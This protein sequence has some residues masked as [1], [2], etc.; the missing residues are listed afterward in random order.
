[1]SASGR[2]RR[3][4]HLKL[5]ARS[6]LF[7]ERWYLARYPDVGSQ[8]LDAAVH[9]L[10]HGGLEGRSPSPEFN[11]EW[12][13]ERNADVRQAGLNPLIHFLENGKAEGRRIRPVGEDSKQRAIPRE[14]K[15][16]SSIVGQYSAETVVNSPVGNWRAGRRSFA[17]LELKRESLFST[18]GRG[19]HLASDEIVIDGLAFSVTPS[20]NQKLRLCLEWMESPTSRTFA[21]D[22][23]ELAGVIQD[24]MSEGALSIVDCW[25]SDD[26]TLRFRIALGSDWSVKPAI[27]RCF[28]QDTAG[29]LQTCAEVALGGSGTLFVDTRLGSRF[30]P[31]LLILSD[32][33][34]NLLDCSMFAFPSLARGGLHYS[35]RVSVSS[36]GSL[37]GAQG[38][39]LDLLRTAC[40]NANGS[41]VGRIEIDLSQAT[42][43]EPLVGEDLLHWLANDLGLEIAAVGSTASTMWLA[44]RVAD[45]PGR[46]TDAKRLHGGTIMLPA[47]AIPSLH[48]LY[49]AMSECD[50]SFTRYLVA[51]RSTREPLIEWRLPLRADLPFGQNMPRLGLEVAGS[52]N[53]AVPLAIIFDNEP[54]HLAKSL[55]PISRDAPLPIDSVPIPGERMTLSVIVHSGP[56]DGASIAALVKSLSNQDGNPDVE[57]ILACPVQDADRTLIE[58]M[59]SF[60]IVQPQLQAVD[61]WTRAREAAEIATGAKLLFVSGQLLLHDPRTLATLWEISERDGVGTVSC[62]LVV[63]KSEGKQVGCASHIGYLASL[64]DNGG[65]SEIIWEQRSLEHS[66]LPPNLLLAA[67]SPHCLLIDSALWRQCSDGI[68]ALNDQWLALGIELARRGLD[69]ICLTWLTASHRPFGPDLAARSRVADG[70]TRVSSFRSFWRP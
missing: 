7:N 69:N 21:S 49:A 38:F 66:L 63:E 11:G 51:D 2:A 28:Q 24:R 55:F 33:N 23:D 48:L 22:P 6:D 4:H 25:L 20:G 15:Q 35:E 39:S 67:N 54:A 16:G 61:A 31:V 9:Y 18:D 17:A 47:A 27:F 60:S 13:L 46:P 64:E 58:T 45:L 57:V 1:M 68:V 59:A 43:N 10:E 8:G 37:T 65:K 5:L 42:G 53:L 41:A 32:P 26:F 44:E 14:P 12:Y 36:G 3:G 19:V 30:R 40:G 29:K 34:G 62:A 52:T 50:D 56:A 70:A